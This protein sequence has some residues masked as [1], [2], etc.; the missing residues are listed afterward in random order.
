MDSAK[1]N[2]WMQVAGIFALVASL[3]FVGM[4]MKQEQEIALSAAY[5]ARTATLV[6][7]LIATGTDDVTRSARLKLQ[8]GDTD[9]TPHERLAYRSMTNA[10]REL[11]QNSHYQ[12]VQGYLDE[13]HWRSVR[14][15][16]KSQLQIPIARESLLSDNLRP[17]FRLVVDEIDRELA[18]EADAAE[19]N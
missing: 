17:S 7:F 6:E 3:L 9:L 14:G 18:A 12:Y 1:L 11:M 10:G 5:Q 4:Q 8:S 13:E 2:D 16:I 19:T 15:V